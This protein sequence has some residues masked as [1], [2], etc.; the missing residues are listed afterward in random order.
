MSAHPEPRATR[1]IRAETAGSSGLALGPN[2]RGRGGGDVEASISVMAMAH[3][4]TRGGIGR[5][6]AAPLAQNGH[7]QRTDRLTRRAPPLVELASITL[8]RSARA[9]IAKAG[10]DLVR[11]RWRR[12][13]VDVALDCDWRPDAC[14]DR[15]DDLDDALTTVG[16]RFDTIT[17]RDRRGRL[18]CA[19]VDANVA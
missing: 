5:P 10:D 12:A 18:R 9:R 1:S 3:Q 8:A 13:V 16:A 11:R 6:R 2:Q 4:R 7:E 15:A 19:P 14:V 17:G